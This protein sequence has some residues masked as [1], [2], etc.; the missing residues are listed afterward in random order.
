MYNMTPNSYKCEQRKSPAP[1][2]PERDSHYKKTMILF[3][4]RSN[5]WK[6]LSFDSFKQ[7]TTTC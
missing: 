5:T 6:D 3:F 4:N 1:D 7:C 2:K